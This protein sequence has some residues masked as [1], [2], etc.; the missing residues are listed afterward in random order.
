[1]EGESLLIS[2]VVCDLDGTLL[3]AE[4]ALSAKTIATLNSIRARGIKIYLASGRT[5]VSMLPFYTQLQLNTPMICYNGAEVRFP[6]G[7]VLQSSLTPEV[8]NQVISF[9]MSEGVHLNLYQGDLW[10][11]EDPES[12][13]AVNY[14]RISGLTPTQ[15]PLESLR[16]IAA[17]KALFI[18]QPEELAALKPKLEST[19]RD[20]AEL[21]SS[22]PHFLEVLRRGVNKGEAVKRVMRH[23]GI[24]LSEVIAFGDGLNDLELLNVVGHGVAM[25]NARTAL[26]E[27]AQDIAD[28]HDED[29][30]A[31]YLDRY[32]AL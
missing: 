1:M 19:L 9:S 29:G 16:G 10:Y 18:A 6:T 2:A 12:I 31:C 27:V 3:N 11:V 32:L 20:Q 17:T 15:A 5:R 30:V 8:V 28:H 7:E 14:A 23:E 13:E 26:K 24:L 21:T 4:H 25:S 22:L